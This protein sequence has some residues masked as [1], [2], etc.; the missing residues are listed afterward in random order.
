VSGARRVPSLADLLAEHGRSIPDLPAVACQDVR[1]TWHQLDERVDR[2]AG[3]LA[4]DGVGRGDRVLWLGQN[5]HRVLEL[6]LASGR[7]GAVMCPANW[8]LSDTELA[9]VIDDVDP[10]VVIWQQAEIGAVVDIARAKAS[11]AARWIQHDG[12][13]DASEYEAYLTAAEPPIERP[14]VP[15]DDPVVMIYTAAFG[16]RPNGALLSHRAWL[17]QNLVTAVVQGTTA[18]DVFLNSG[19]MFH[20]GTLRHTL[21][22]FQLGGLNVVARR[23]DAD[24]FCRLIERYRCTGAFLEK[25]T[26]EQ[27]VS[28]NHDGRYD[29]SSLRAAPGPPEWNAMITTEVRRLRN[30]F[31]QTELAGLVTFADTATPGLGGAGRPSPIAVVELLGIDG[32]VVPD[33]E[34]GEIAVRGPMVM[35]GYHRRPELTK[36]RQRGGWHHTT[37]LGRREADG[38]ISFVGP[39]SRIVKSA[40]ENIYPAEV[41]ACIRS[42]SGVRDAG[43]IGVPDPVWT[44]SVLAVVTLENGAGVTEADVIA[45]CRGRIASYKKPKRVEFVPRLPRTPTGAVDYDALDERFG[46]GGYPAK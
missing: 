31:G 21:S 3:A 24:E 8:R 44:Q 29:L 28:A 14:L 5:C 1:L 25:P 7:V 30:G 19:P 38:T 10:K 9:F 2:L 20:V 15:A 32:E 41:E 22:T 35:N 40:S 4:S 23:V 12:P 43:V 18:A 11:I 46:G 36:L 26:I 33:G 39:A 16:G 42:L 37:D 45:H 6:L 27:I 34:V 13:D 17:F